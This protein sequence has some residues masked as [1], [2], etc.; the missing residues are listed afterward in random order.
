MKKVE[1][2]NI[3][4]FREKA[5]SWDENPMRVALSEAIFSGLVAQVPL[6]KEMD[7]LEIG[8]GTGLLTVPMAGAVH[9]VAAFDLSKEMLEVLRQKM[10]A[11]SITNVR[12]HV[13]DFPNKEIEESGFDIIYSGM[14]MHHIANIPGILKQAYRF[15]K[16]SGYLAIGDLE[17]EDGSFHGDNQ[18]VCHFGFDGEKIAETVR[19]AGFRIQTVQTVHTIQKTVSPSE[20]RGYPVFLLIAQK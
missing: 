1:Q 8:A 9:T 4:R 15:L 17:K 7:A 19:D 16:P 2:E 18:G 5:S 14:T 10:E 6:T 3:D 20:T 11:L 12:V 13:T